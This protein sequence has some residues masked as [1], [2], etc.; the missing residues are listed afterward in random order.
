MWEHDVGKRYYNKQ[1]RIVT[2]YNKHTSAVKTT[3]VY[4]KNE[5]A[6]LGRG[7]GRSFA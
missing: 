7:S 3:K 1:H 6:W 4:R 2:H 5:R